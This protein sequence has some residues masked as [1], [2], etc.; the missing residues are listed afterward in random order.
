MGTK[1]QIKYRANTENNGPVLWPTVKICSG[2]Q[3]IHEILTQKGLIKPLTGQ[4]ST[5]T[6]VYIYF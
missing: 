5:P 3:A 6:H 2:S 1:I 4:Q